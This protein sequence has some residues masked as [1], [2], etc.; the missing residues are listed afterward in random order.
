MGTAVGITV[1]GTAASG[2]VERAFEWLHW[3]DATFSTYR[4]DSEVS[5]IGRGELRLDDAPSVVRHVF[6]RCDEL[7]EATGGRFTIRPAAPDRPAIDPSGLVKGWSVDEAAMILR[8]AGIENFMINAGGD[9]LCSGT[10]PDS[11]GWPI[12]IRHPLDPLAVAAVVTIGSGAVATSGTY[13]RGDHIWGH[14]GTTRLHSATVVG[15]DLGTTDALATAIYADPD[16]LGWMAAFP[17]HELVLIGEDDLVRWTSGL[18][19]MIS[20]EDES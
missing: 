2:A 5:R 12:G 13:E 10:P 15:T 1:V 19:G 6:A 18:D 16:D 17:G 9:I 3:V 8:L 14:R 7:T 4:P 11:E 20:L